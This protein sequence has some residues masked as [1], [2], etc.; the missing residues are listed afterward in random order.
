MNIQT[1]SL[2][3]D[4]DEINDSFHERGMTDGLPIIPPTRLRVQQMLAGVDRDPDEILGEFPPAFHQTTIAMLAVNA[5]MAGCKPEYMPVVVAAIEAILEPPF[6]LYGINSTT[7]PVSP[8]VIV[9]GPIIER[10]GMNAGYNVFGSGWRANASIGR[11]VRLAMVNIGGGRPGEGD[12]ATHGHPGKFSYCIAENESRNPWSPLHVQRGFGPGQS[13]VTVFGA[14]APHLINDHFSTSGAGLLS[15]VAGVFASIGS[16][17]SYFND[18]EICLVL[19]PEHA[20]RLAGEGW[21]LARIR[22]YLFAKARLRAGALRAVG[23]MEKLMARD[24]NL[25]DDDEMIPLTGCPEDILILVAGG[26][27]QHSMAI[28]SFGITRAISKVVASEKNHAAG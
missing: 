8:L 24:Y 4:L 6:N 7:H 26:A 27:G 18:G 22:Q 23:R 5:V 13:T 17:N 25:L 3:G 28:H 9:N 2:S 1:L 15:V 11:A 20:S 21:T 12:R 10:I 16:N 19:G 14:D